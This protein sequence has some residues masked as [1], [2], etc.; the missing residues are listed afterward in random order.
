[1]KP[2]WWVSYRFLSV[3]QEEKSPSCKLYRKAKSTELQ[4]FPSHKR[5]A[6]LVC[7]TTW[8]PLPTKKSSLCKWE[9]ILWKSISETQEKKKQCKTKQKL[10]QNLTKSRNRG[11]KKW[12]FSPASFSLKCY[13]STS[14][15]RREWSFSVN[16]IF[17][18]V[19]Y[20]AKRQEVALFFFFF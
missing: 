11:K 17:V 1:M 13:H 15:W 7:R 16:L 20:L 5:C 10:Q 4:A 8:I 12:C 19:G 6:L 14:F 9:R 18:L 2:F 3:L